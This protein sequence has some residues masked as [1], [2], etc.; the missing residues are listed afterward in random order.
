MP[1]PPLTSLIVICWSALDRVFVA[2]APGMS[3]C[4]GTGDTYR[5]ALASCLEAMQ[6]RAEHAEQRRQPLPPPE[7]SWSPHA[8]A[9]ETE[10]STVL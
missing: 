10:H 9:E 2:K 1:N 4:I 5:A 6:W 8:A 7:L 3:G